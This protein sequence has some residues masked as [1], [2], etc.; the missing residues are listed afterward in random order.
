MSADFETAVDEIFDLFAAAWNT[1]GYPVDYENLRNDGTTVKV[2]P[3]T[4]TPWAR[5]NLRHVTG[6][7]AAIGN[8]LFDRGGV[9]TVQIFIVVGVSLTPAYQLAKTVANAFQG[10]STPS[11]VW[12]RNVR[13]NEIGNDGSWY[14]TNV[15]A[16]FEYDERI[17]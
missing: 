5:V 13:I 7:N 1:T 16:D 14:Q 2:P 4:R 12:F 6:G 15:L 11:A 9:L 3:S 8:K 10:Q 17:T